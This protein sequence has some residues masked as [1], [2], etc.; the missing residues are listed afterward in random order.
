MW[1]RKDDR[2]WCDEPIWGNIL[3]GT[4]DKGCCHDQID[5]AMWI[6]ADVKK[7]FTTNLR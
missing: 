1:N 6:V 3:M 4:D 2:G 7:H 5:S